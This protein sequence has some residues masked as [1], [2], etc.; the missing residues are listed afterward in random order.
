MMQ[1]IN[2]NTGKVAANLEYSSHGCWDV[3]PHI[4]NRYRVLKD[5]ELITA[6]DLNTSFGLIEVGKEL[7][8]YNRVVNEIVY[9]IDDD[10]EYFEVFCDDEFTID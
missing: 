6:I 9:V 7:P 10:K 5:G 8:G 4:D 2:K 1:Y 3:I